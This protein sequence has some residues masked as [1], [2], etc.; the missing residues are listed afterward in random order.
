MTDL[1]DYPA[2]AD[3]S[4]LEGFRKIYRLNYPFTVTNVNVFE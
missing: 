1:S 2:I 4:G 3:S